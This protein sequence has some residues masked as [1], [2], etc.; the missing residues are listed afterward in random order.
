MVSDKCVIASNTSAL[1]IKEIASVARKPER[2]IGMHYFSPVEKMQL[3]EIITTEKTSKE[4]LKVAANL[5]LRQK[6]LVVV[7][8][9]SVFLFFFQT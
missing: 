6:K 4:T 3:L 1:P 9:V 8:K 2:I 5:G 7:V